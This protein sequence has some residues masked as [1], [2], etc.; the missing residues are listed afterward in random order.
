MTQVF[1]EIDRLG[2]LRE[3]V[4]RAIRRQISAGRLASGEGLTEIAIAE[5]I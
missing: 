1:P 5:S 4:Y 2:G 3:S